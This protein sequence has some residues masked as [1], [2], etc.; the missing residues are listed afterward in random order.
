MKV[1]VS[2]VVEQQGHWGIDNL[3]TRILRASEREA[4][5]ETSHLASSRE[6]K[7]VERKMSKSLPKVFCNE[8][9]LIHTFFRRSLLFA[10][11]CTAPMI[12]L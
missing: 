7:D 10:R 11:R 9:R 1:F 12:H 6:L 8:L 5:Q 2:H 3:K 4:A